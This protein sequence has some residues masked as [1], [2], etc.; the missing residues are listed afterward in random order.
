[1]ERKN[2]DIRIL[3]E[4]YS[5]LQAESINVAMELG[6]YKSD[7]LR[8]VCNDFGRGV[9]AKRNIPKGQPL[10]MYNGELVTYTEGRKRCATGKTPF[11]FFFK[12]HE[13]SWCL[14]ASEENFTFGRLINHGRRAANV[15]PEACNDANGRPAVRFVALMDIPAGSELLY[16][17]G[18]RDPSVLKENPWLRD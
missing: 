5:S 3:E 11:L 13:R 8:V 16:D 15:K 1:M 6:K 17:Y 18:E 7:W 12:I 10:C 4:T 14:D 9:V 2:E